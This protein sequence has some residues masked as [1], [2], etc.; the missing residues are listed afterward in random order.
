M[1]L[2]LMCVFAGVVGTISA[3]LRTA[4]IRDI[5]TQ[6]EPLS[7]DAVEVYRSLASADA[8]VAGEFLESGRD[9]ASV[10]EQY[11][12]AIAR[13]AESLASAATRSGDQGLTA[14]RIADVAVQL[15]VYTGFV[16]QARAERGSAAGGGVESLKRAS[17]LMQSTILRRAQALQRSESER[18]DDRYERARSVPV[19]AVAA[20]LASLALLSAVQVFLLIKTKRIVNIGL[21]LATIAILGTFLWWVLAL[22]ASHPEL[23]DSRRHSE[24]VTDALGQAQIAARQARATEILALVAP[25]TASYERD[26]LERMQRL[27]RRE[28]TGGALGAARR[29]SPEAEGSIATAVA[30]A[31]EWQAA[32][33]QIHDLQER[34]RRADAVALAIR[35]DG[36]GAAKS[37]ND[38]DA[39]LAEAAANERAAF[40]RDIDQAQGALAGLAAAVGILPIVAAGS[41]AW[42][43]RHRLREYPSVV[44]ADG[45]LSRPLSTGRRVGVVSPG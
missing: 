38:L 44:L 24:S 29:L 11:G 40:T 22:R 15:P 27:V 36:S 35:T 39:T 5:E 28:G 3:S 17:D 9:T 13:A 1:L 4:A 12:Q 43:I 30:Q 21:T 33:A 45:D 23:D 19:F 18:L 34:G 32:H 37:F 42:G 10:R 41:A 26:Y 25:G 20:G 2:V 8:I 6:S 7:A 31:A 14:D 16:E